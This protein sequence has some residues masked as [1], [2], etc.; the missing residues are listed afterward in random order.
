MHLQQFRYKRCAVLSDIHLFY[1]FFFLM[2][3]LCQV[4]RKYIRYFPTKILFGF[5]P[6]PPSQLDGTSFS[7]F[8]SF[9]FWAILIVISD[10]KRVSIAEKIKKKTQVVLSGCFNRL[11]NLILHCYGLIRIS[12]WGFRR[13][14]FLWWD[15]R[16]RGLGSG[17]RCCCG[18]RAL[19]GR[20]CSLAAARF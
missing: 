13:F 20:R 4:G 19:L 16:V 1:F 14:R 6:L 7:L 18:C 17:T 11:S 5:S 15:C 3:D 9:S 8:F 10:L 12:R 2:Q